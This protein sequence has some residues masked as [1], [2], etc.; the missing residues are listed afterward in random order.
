MSETNFK[1]F[2]QFVSYA[3][4]YWLHVLVFMAIFV[5]EVKTEV[6]SQWCA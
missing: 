5:G 3:S 2:I 1:Y 4:V 6:S